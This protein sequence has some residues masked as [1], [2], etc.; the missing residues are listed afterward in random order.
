M[1][2]SD[3]PT[4]ATI[5]PYAVFDIGVSDT[6][7][8]ASSGFGHEVRFGL[9]VDNLF[10]RHYLNTAYT[11]TDY[12]GNDFIRGIIAAPRSVTGSVDIHF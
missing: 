7:Q 4:A 3:L 2:S 8:F 5:K 10:N 9:N 12:N 11:D 6:V 1:C